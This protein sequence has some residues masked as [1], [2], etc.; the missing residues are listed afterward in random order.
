MKLFDGADT[1]YLEW[2]SENPNGFVATTD[3]AMQRVEYPVVHLASHRQISGPAR[4]TSGDYLKVCSLFLEELE[5]WATAS[6]SRPLTWCKTCAAKARKL[7]AS[8]DRC[9]ALIDGVW[10]L[11]SVEGLLLQDQVVRCQECLGPVRLH[12]A[13]P[14]G[15]PKAHAEHSTG[16]PGCS[17]GH[18][19]NGVRSLHPQ[20]IDPETKVDQGGGMNARELWTDDELRAS[21]VSYL[22]M[23][24]KFL[25]NKRFVR[26]DY[27][28]S[29]A[30]QFG[31]TPK[32]FEYRM[33]NISFVLS[34]MGRR[35]IPG[36]PPARNVG[37]QVA[38]RIESLIADVES[39]PVAPAAALAIAVSKARALTRI[40]VKP[41]GSVA[42]AA[43]LVQVTQY[44]RDPK[45]KAWVLAQANGLCECCSM[46][47]P[48]ET[49][50]GPFLEVHHVRTLAENGR[51]T[52]CNA[53]AICPNCHRR[54]HFGKDAADQIESLYSRI[55]RLVR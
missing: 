18:Y 25:E 24:N 46:P 36:L 12:R 13:G 8:N 6:S 1:A 26:A 27:Y 5:D 41:E 45:V 2:I 55:S 49:F 14:E 53:V 23:Q 43:A 4:F 11:R 52:V 21:V 40:E 29:L 50:D 38:T 32:A 3:K 10:E 47:A 16:H 15:V 44:K 9:H 35:W 39:R 34:T 31:R 22:E 20:A 30:E 54:L 48:F 17:L 42:P 28:R 51:D 37:E 19:F 33:Q 7:Y